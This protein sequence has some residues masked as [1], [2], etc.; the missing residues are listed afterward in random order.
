MGR[1][2]QEGGRRSCSS[3]S[4]STSVQRP[5]QLPAALGPAEDQ[6]EDPEAGVVLG[7]LESSDPSPG[8]CHP[9][10]L[11]LAEQVGVDRG[12]AW[13]P[14]RT[15]HL[16]GPTRPRSPPSARPPRAPA[17]TAPATGTGRGPRLRPCAPPPGRRS[18]APLCSSRR[19]PAA[20]D[21]CRCPGGGWGSRSPPT[22][23]VIEHVFEQLQ[24]T[25]RLRQPVKTWPVDC[26]RARAGLS[27][28]RPSRCSPSRPG[29]RALHGSPSRDWCARCTL[30]GV[31]A[32]HSLRSSVVWASPTSVASYPRAMAPCRAS[33][34][35]T[36]RSARP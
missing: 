8:C 14:R 13:C 6:V 12:P 21:P 23:A 33:T 29:V 31:G 36:R 15:R 24:G 17:T 9:P 25:P 18:A 26:G 7:R 11:A 30:S 4:S 3:R 22:R 19:A 28:S 5:D 2:R 20:V 16:P 1:R 35:C 32:P 10:H 34:G 27:R